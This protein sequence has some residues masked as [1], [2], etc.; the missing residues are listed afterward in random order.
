MNSRV[1]AVMMGLSLAWA[2]FVLASE[3]VRLLHHNV[4]VE[5]V[6]EHL[7]IQ[8]GQSVVVGLRIEMDEG[9]HTYWKNPAAPGMATSIRWILPHGFEAGGI[10]WP[11][12][13]AFELFE[14]VSYGYEGEVLLPVRIEV[15][16]EVAT[17]RVELAA[18]V[19]WLACQES[20]VPGEV[21][22]T[23]DL[24]VTRDPPAL[25]QRWQRLFDQARRDLP[26]DP[27]PDQVVAFWSAD[28]KKIVLRVS[29][30]VAESETKATFFAEKDEEEN[31]VLDYE[32]PQQLKRIDQRLEVWL[33]PSPHRQTPIKHLRGVLVLESEDRSDV[34]AVDV[35]LMA[36]DPGGEDLV[37]GAVLL[38]GGAS[39]LSLPLAILYA[40]IGGLTLNLMPC[41]FPVLSIKVLG[42]VQQAG[43][44]RVRIRLHGFVFALGVLLSFWVLTI[45][46]LAL[47]AGGEQLGWGFQFQS[48]AFIALL[49]CLM[50]A[51]G[52]NLFG[53]FEIGLGIMTLAGQTTSRANQGGYCES[54]FSGVLATAVATPCTAP[55]MGPA[56]G[57]ALTLSTLQTLM[58]FTA[59]G[60]GMA[61]PYVVL[62]MF[63]TWLKL[64]PKS[65]PWMETFRQL[66][67]FP[68]FGATIWL[69]WLFGRA[70]GSE[71]ILIL[72][73]GML[74][75]AMATWVFGRWGTVV[76]GVGV[77]WAARVSS[78]ALTAI[79]VALPLW[80]INGLGGPGD[81]SWEPYDEQRLA[82]YQS[83]GRTV[84]VDFTADW[85]LTCKFN[86][87][88][89][90]AS[91]AIRQL[92]VTRNVALLKAD[93][94][95]KDERIAQALEKFGR[96]SVPLYLV[97]SADRSRQPVVLPTVLTR[98]MVIDAVDRASS[99]A[100][101]SMRD[102]E[103]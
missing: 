57:F 43:E 24:P 33:A 69:V 98:R 60:V 1:F 103:R 2:T 97:Y 86:E 15:P 25:D 101:L 12:P 81:L 21:T 67:A 94:T 23:L 31:D 7:A 102:V 30:L 9:W 49:A 41:V 84:F 36:S 14:M 34:L 13:H 54:L 77:R 65:G 22:L 75:L 78:V 95:Q 87:G 52:L 47:R 85:C 48:P 79:A 88:T 37:D 76:R 8:P 27:A 72:L 70:V 51:V 16:P 61:L 5:L 100:E 56:I 82:Q 46:L 96:T 64:L 59:L 11:R 3:P 58:V 91:R 17:N 53:V 83:A 35:P 66:M 93:W 45:V 4:E 92:F 28:E 62:S 71:G 74:V 50:L 40:L 63:P 73:V 44:D 68:M 99:G 39:G 55:L 19:K 38:G 10:Q 29:G 80:A 42:F 26:L 90:L 6:A 18:Q 20:C 32:A 89:V